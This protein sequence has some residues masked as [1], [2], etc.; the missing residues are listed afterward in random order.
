MKKSVTALIGLGSNLG[1]RAAFLARAWEL[2]SQADG[3]VTRKISRF[4]ETEPLV[5]DDF[6]Q[7]NL[8]PKYLNAAGLLET[9]LEASAL[10]Q[11]MLDIEQQLGRVRKVRWGA[12]TIDLDLLLFGDCILHTEHLIVPHPQMPFRRFV[13]EPSAEIAPNLRHP[14]IGKTILEML[15]EI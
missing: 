13:L 8:P 15:E 3:I 1:D 4:Y 14:V 12:R 9:T 5:A 7:K 6:S 10:L 11:T 2:L